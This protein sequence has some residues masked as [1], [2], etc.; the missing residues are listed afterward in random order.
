MLRAPENTLNMKRRLSLRPVGALAACCLTFGACA[1]PTASKPAMDAAAPTGDG[2]TSGVDG[3]YSQGDATADDG[4]GSG[5]D[6]ASDAAASA[7]GQAT[8]AWDWVGIVGTGQSLS[9]GQAAN[10]PKATTQPYHNLKLSLGMAAVPP[11]D[12]TISG[13]SMVPLVEP[14]RKVAMLYPSAYPVNI[15][16]ETPHTVMGNEISSLFQQ[17]TGGDYVTVHTVVGENGQGL[18]VINKTA[19]EMGDAGMSTGR[20]YAATLFEASAIARLASAANKTYG[21]GAIVITHGESDAGNGAY[22]SGLVQLWSDYNKDLS[23]ITGQTTSIPMFVNQQHSVPMGKGATSASTLAEW[24]VGVDH[25]GDIVC[26]GPK[27]QY[28]YFT[29]N[30]HLTATGYELLGEKTGEVYFQKVVMGQDWQPLQ[31]I[32]ATRSGMVVTV[33]FHVPVPPLTWDTTFPSPHP[34]GYPQWT[35]AQGFE[36]IAGGSPAN[37]TSV[38][39]MGDDTVLITTDR[40]L[41][42]LAVK[43]AYAYTADG[44]PMPGGTSRWGNL[45]DSDP[46]VGVTTN[47]AQPNYCVSFSMTV[48]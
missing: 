32:S 15:Y 18:S 44:A 34:T 11:F 19:V 48:Q 24:S 13:L 46:M 3:S 39:I 45:R 16:G 31:P 22:E 43:V 5:G 42:N 6:A 17:A 35:S 36:L 12:P 21:I 47:T 7:D 29:D 27:Y 41:T 1:G 8:K 4:A 30:V 28:P 2:P 38:M 23:A 20:A 37:I 26:S 40:D 14:I 9:V 25:P 33:K 10:P